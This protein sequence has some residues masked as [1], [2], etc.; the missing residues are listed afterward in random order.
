MRKWWPLVAVCLGAFILL[1]DVTIVNVALPQMAEALDAPF[2]SLQWVVDAYAL[3]LAALLLAAGSIADLFGHRKL[4]VS[5]LALFA[6]ASLACGLAPNAGVLVAARAVQGAGGAAMFA[7]SAALLG[8]TYHGRDRGTAFGI[9]GAVNGAAAAT[10]PILGGLLTE[11]IGWQAI[12]L[13]NLPIAAV[14]VLLTLRVVRAD[15]AAR[16]Q[17]RTGRVDVPGA[18]T[19]T[20]A[21]AAVTYGLIRSAETGWTSPTVVI[22]FAVAAASLIAFVLVETR[23]GRRGGQPMLDLALLRRPSFAGLMG[24]ALL[25]QGGAFGCLVLI[26]LW[27]QSVLGLGPV[28]GGLALTPMA[29]VSFLVA[30]IA[31]RH[32]QRLAPRLPIGIGLLLIAAGM[33][34]LYDAM[35]AD[36]TA[37]S[38]VIGLAVAGA[39]VGLA[40]PVLVS[41]ATGSVPP[42]RMGMAAGAV[43]TFRQLGMT[44][45]IAVLGAVFTHTAQKRLSGLVP[46]A[47]DAASA[48]AGGQAQRLVA[49]APHGGRGEARELVHRVFAD[50]MQ[51]VFLCS[52]AAAAV[53]GLLVLALVRPTP[54][55]PAPGAPGAAEPA[56]SAEPASAEEPVTTGR[57]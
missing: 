50:G 56:G 57:Q 49:A 28:E 43:N 7:T 42:Q 31:G 6:L 51:D 36:A 53:G 48:L 37:S 41:A 55:Q 5:G 40:T 9:W 19:F 3:S 30:A 4:Y 33:Y 24:G 26:S 14:A 39:G 21:A 29:V 38:L 13:V 46:D 54:T 20:L 22:S 35:S 17:A 15:Q 52:A 25:L 1:V 47:H 2:S 16:P 11:H 23:L 27:L 34:L 8:A 10:G 18:V 44:L 32:I 12:F 45:A